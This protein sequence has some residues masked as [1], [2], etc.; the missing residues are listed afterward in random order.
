MLAALSL[1]LLSILSDQTTYSE[2]IR[3]ILQAK[4]VS[5]HREGGEGPFPLQTYQ[6]VRRRGALIRYVVLEGKMPPTDASSDVEPLTLQKGLTD[7][8][9]IDLQLWVSDGL[10]E[11]SKTDLIA[12]N[13]V[14]FSAD[15]SLESSG[16]KSVRTEGAPYSEIL[17]FTAPK[18]MIIK[19]YMAVPKSP[20]CVR[21]VVLAWGKKGDP[22]PFTPTETLTSHVIGTWSPGYRPVS[23]QGGVA[24]KQGD[25]LLAKVT[26]QPS[27]KVE[28]GGLALKFALGD[29]P[30]TVRWLRL[31]ERD[32]TIPTADG[33]YPM[34][35]EI[36]LDR[37]GVLREILPEIKQYAR[38]MRVEATLPSGRTVGLMGIYTWDAQW[39][40]AYNFAKGIELPVGTKIRSQIA[41]DNS[42]HAFGDLRTTPK[43]IPFGPGEND[44]LNWTHIMLEEA[45]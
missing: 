43:P 7:R 6:Q 15:V 45:P 31:G 18:D 12:P 42:G 20:Q 30:S 44:E 24:I 13:V 29:K 10:P 39:P 38:Q 41:Y 40:G 32:F 1:T 35:S 4:C 14:P 11:G 17:S 2:A 27:G 28:D 23:F 34:V 22:T 5:C 25:L 9:L 8:D 36:T 37:A 16:A 21:Q 19:S 33:L 26:Y 3:P